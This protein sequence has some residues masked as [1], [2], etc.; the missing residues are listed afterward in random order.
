MVRGRTRVLWWSGAAVGSLALIVLGGALWL[1]RTY[2][3]EA[4]FTVLRPPERVWA[5]F[6]QPGRWARRF[7]IVQ[8]VEDGSNTPMSIGAQRRV[9]V[10]LPGGETLVSEILVTDFATGRRYADRHLGD[11]LDGAPLPVAN[12]TDRLEFD[13]DGQG[14]TRVVFSGVFEVT[15]LWN[16]WLAYFTWQPI[17]ARVIA[18]VRDTYVHSIHIDDTKLAM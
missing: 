12:V 13:P 4:D 2:Q 3:F 6:A 15:G 7:P 8:S 10:H 18:Q 5:W 9:R 11:W 14:H 16:R 1:P 17:A